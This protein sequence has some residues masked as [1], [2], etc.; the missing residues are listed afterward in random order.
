MKRICLASVLAFSICLIA[1]KPAKTPSLPP[2]DIFFTMKGQPFALERT[3]P[4]IMAAFM[5]TDDQRMA[6]N[7]EYQETVADPQLREKGAS[8]KN[9]PAA[10]DTDRQE[11]RKQ[12]AEARAELQKRA[13]T[14]LTT[15]QK[16]LIPKIQ[17]A[18]TEAL[19]E[20]REAFP[21]DPG[22][23]KGDKSKAKDLEEKIKVEAEDL[24]VQ[25]LEKFL[26]PAQMEAVRQAATQQRESEEQSRKNKLGK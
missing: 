25:K 5:F 16:A 22:A 19:K 6:L 12:Q 15:E 26:T 17:A 1:A 10:T 23:T 9:N 4:G 14:I 2:G 18:A 3:F 24:F 13:E 21:A 20:A 8:L 7:E 11:M